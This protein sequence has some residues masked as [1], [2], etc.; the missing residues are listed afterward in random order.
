MKK[1]LSETLALAMTLSLLPAAFAAGGTA[2]AST[3]A[4]EVDGKKVEFQMYALKDAAGNPTNYVKLRDVAHV[5]NGTK[6]QFSVGYDGSI[7]VTT[8]Q[9]YA[10]AGGEMTT[11]YSGDRAYR[12]GSG[13]VKVNGQSASLESII[14]TDDAGGDYTYFKLRDLGSALGFKV[15]WT[16]DRG[17]FIETGGASQPTAPASDGK[18]T[19]DQLQGIWHAEGDDTVIDLIISGNQITEC[20]H[21][22]GSDYVNYILNTGTITD[23][24]S[25][26]TP[27]D[28]VDETKTYPYAIFWSGTHERWGKGDLEPKKYSVTVTPDNP[29]SAGGYGYLG[30]YYID[31]VDLE[32]NRIGFKY[33][34]DLLKKV[35]Y[36]RHYEYTKASSSPVYDMYVADLKEAKENNPYNKYPTYVKFPKVPDFGGIF[37]LTDHA[38]HGKLEYGSWMDPAW[39]DM[40]NELNDELASISDITIYTYKSA[41]AGG[42][43]KLLEMERQYIEILKVCG[44]KS[45]MAQTALGGRGHYYTNKEGTSVSFNW[46]KPSGY[47]IFPP[48]LSIS[49]QSTR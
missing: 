41:D 7:S 49:V 13:S 48:A 29:V 9:P 19:L 5:L 20:R 45:E 37:G 26:Y 32:N 36:R 21:V 8:G 4:V 38:N 11:P 17:V 10:D 43:D 34:E 42:Y 27:K 25:D 44:F 31:E 23:F 16:A 46:Q 39:V 2:Y 24:Q 30:A 18:L 3:Q 14:L 33:M 35:E 47:Q 15:D 6:A 1:I 22:I 12:D 28:S 40:M